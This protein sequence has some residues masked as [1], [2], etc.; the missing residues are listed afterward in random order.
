MEILPKSSNVLL[1]ALLKQ[2]ELGSIKLADK[3]IAIKIAGKFR[4]LKRSNRRTH[5]KIHTL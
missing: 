5:T 2:E 3:L 1:Y 4:Q